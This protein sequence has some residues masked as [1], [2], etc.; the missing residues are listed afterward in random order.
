MEQTALFFGVSTT[1]T[2]TEQIQG[3]FKTQLSA[4]AQEISRKIQEKHGEVE[5]IDATIQEY[6]ATANLNMERGATKTK[7]KTKPKAKDP[8]APK[9]KKVIPP[10]CRCQAR[11]WPAAKDGG[12][13]D[14]TDQCS[15]AAGSTGLCTRHAKSEAICNIP[16]TL[17]EN[18]HHMGL[19]HGRMSQMQDGESE[20]PPYKDSN[21]VVRLC[22]YAVCPELKKHIAD[23]VEEGKCLMPASKKKVTKKQAQTATA[24]ELASAM[25]SPV[26]QPSL[27]VN[28]PVVEETSEEQPSIQVNEPVVEETSEEQP[29]VEETSEEQPPVEETSEEQ[30]PVEETSEEQ[31]PAE[32]TSEEHHILIEDG[33]ME[34]QIAPEAEDNDEE[35]PEVEEKLYEG[36]LFYVEKDGSDI[37]HLGCDEDA[38]EYGE[39]IGQWVDGKPVLDEEW[40]YLLEL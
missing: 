19:W 20:Y 15:M 31:P 12:A 22:M 24:E 38:D 23:Q 35:A 4:H 33:L 11:V 39:L 1:M 13:E 40:K 28:E 14:G 18:G 17:D 32:E 26:E 16:L 9:T 36:T 27:Q 25:D 21:N 6:L 29:P 30:P 37:Y 8:T 7:T 3:L 5:G 2:T 34:L 10:E